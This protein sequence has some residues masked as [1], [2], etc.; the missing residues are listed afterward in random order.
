M[1]NAGLPELGP[2]GATY[3]LTRASWPTPRTRSRTYGLSLV[4]GCCGTTPSTASGRRAGPR[5][6]PRSAT[7]ARAGRRVAVSERPVPAG[8]VVPVHRRA[9]QRQRFRR[10]ARRCSRSPRRLRRHRP[11]PDAR[12]RPPARPVH[13]LRRTRWRRRHASACRSASHRV[14]A[15]VLDSTEPNVLEAGLEL[16]AAGQSSTPS[17]TRTATD[18]ESR[19]PASCR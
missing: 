2:Q 14:A 18:R 11:R 3:P 13:R 17:T 7:A 4:G 15:V 5:P 16:L 9:H 19:S 6:R 10:S 12:R 1:P 8:R